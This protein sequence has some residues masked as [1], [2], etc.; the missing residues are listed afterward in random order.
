MATKKIKISKGVLI[1][2]YLRVIAGIII[3]FY[4][5]GASSPWKEIIILIG[6]LIILTSGIKVSFSNI[7]K[8]ISKPS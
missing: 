5:F 3:M 6:G 2:L 8:E 1:F 4:P 7:F